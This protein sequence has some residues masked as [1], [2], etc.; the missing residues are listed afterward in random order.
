LIDRGFLTGDAATAYVA[1][2]KSAADA[3]NDDF[4]LEVVDFLNQGIEFA[5]ASPLP[6]AAEAGQWVFKEAE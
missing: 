1:E 4:P 2:G 3:T 6:D 5:I